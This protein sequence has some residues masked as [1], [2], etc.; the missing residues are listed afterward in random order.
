MDAHMEFYYD[1]RHDPAIMR[2]R[3]RDLKIIKI[4]FYIF[5]SFLSV[6]FLLAI[7]MA[8]NFYLKFY[9][10]I[11]Y[12]LIL[13]LF[14]Y[15]FILPY[16]RAFKYGITMTSSKLSIWG[17]DYYLS[18]IKYAEIVRF[19]GTGGIYEFK[20]EWI[21]SWLAIVLKNNKIILI[22]ATDTRDIVSLCKRIR[23][24]IG[25]PEQQKIKTYSAILGFYIWKSKIL[26]KI[27]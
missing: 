17:Y 18:D 4:L 11:T 12:I 13:A 14:W 23:E 15:I 20:N 16:L 2:K 21:N 8:K 25:L 22:R 10:I 6:M 19:L 27:G 24:A 1:D 7:Y 5:S 26:S 3:E 9:F